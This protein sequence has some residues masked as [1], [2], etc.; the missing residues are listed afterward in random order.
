MNL[1]EITK[2]E[3]ERLERGEVEPLHQPIDFYLE[4]H[5]D[6][7]PTLREYLWFIID[8]LN[9]KTI[10]ELIN[11]FETFIKDKL[12]EQFPNLASPL[13]Q[14]QLSGEIMRLASDIYIFDDAYVLVK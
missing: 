1:D 5:P 3:K 13:M 14:D 11:G 9:V 8:G 6:R 12:A 10:S 7:C 4:K 2:E